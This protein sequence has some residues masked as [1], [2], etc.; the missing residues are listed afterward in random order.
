MRGAGPNDQLPRGRRRLG[1]GGPALARAALQQLGIRQAYPGAVLFGAR[2]LRPIVDAFRTEF[3]AVQLRYRLLNRQVS[4]MEEAID[5]ALRLAQLAD[6]G[7]IA[8]RVGNV[9]CVISAAPRY[10]DEHRAGV[11]KAAVWRWQVDRM[12]FIRVRPEP[13]SKPDAALRFEPQG[14]THRPAR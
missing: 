14:R 8:T 9:R 10:L 6:S 2:I 7:L 11:T 13:P 3:P 5:V 1:P 12:P 4:L